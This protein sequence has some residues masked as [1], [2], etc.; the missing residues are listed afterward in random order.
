[1]FEQAT[2]QAREQ[3]ERALQLRPDFAAAAYQ[4]A[5]IS[6]GSDIPRALERWRSYLALARGMPEEHDWV[7]RAEEHLKRLQRP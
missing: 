3:F 7:V 2:D 1:M 6:N 5:V 4:L